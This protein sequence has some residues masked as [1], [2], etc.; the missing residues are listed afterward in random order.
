M[1]SLSKRYQLGEAE[2]GYRTLRDTIARIWSRSERRKTRAD[3]WALRDVSF[4]VAEGQALGIIGRNGAG[5]STLLKILSRITEPTGGRARLRGPVASLLEIGTGF[6][7]E[8]TGREN[9]FLS[10]A[11]LGMKRA[12]VTRDLDAIVA[13]AELDKFLDTPV[14][15]YS[16]GMYVRLAF[17][18]AAH[19]TPDILIV[20]EVLAVGDHAFQKKCLRKMEDVSHGGR[21]ILFVSHNMQAIRT[22]CQ[23]A[24]WL[25]N[26]RVREEGT[27]DAV[28]EHYI[29]A[30]DEEQSAEDIQKFIARV[31]PDPLFKL[32]NLSV[33]QQGMP[34]TS[35]LSGRPIDIEA[36]FETCQESTGVHVYIRLFDND[37][38]M[39]IESIH[40]GADTDM[41][42]LKAGTWR[43]SGQIPADILAPRRYALHVGLAIAHGRYLLPEPYVVRLD[44]TASGSVN[45]LYPG[46]TTPARLAPL[47]PWKIEEVTG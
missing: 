22:L 37:G 8:L 7:P 4:N 45:A 25:E 18:V 5:K 41:H 1:E 39:L 6:H 24:I 23:S 28:T 30:G 42:P 26:G 35:V 16:S 9:I 20:D 19:L 33:R 11:I 34:A 2:L 13:F 32:L 40:N 3:L 38:T 21:T 47:F 27:S 43:I 44:V 14:K 17:A 15:R 29:M 46:Y 10:G 36:E 31:P 12:E